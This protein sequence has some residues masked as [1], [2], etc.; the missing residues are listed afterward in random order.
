[1][2]SFLAALGCALDDVDCLYLA[3]WED[4]I[5]AQDEARQFLP[6]DSPI[7]AFMQILPTGT[8]APVCV[9]VS[10]CLS[11]CLSV[12][13]CLYVCGWVCACV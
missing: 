10:V 1:M 6:I 11:V 12:H 4:M 7:S 5:T 8:Q 13:V 2:S 3:D 9:C